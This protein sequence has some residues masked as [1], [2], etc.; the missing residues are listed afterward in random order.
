MTQKAFVWGDLTIAER[1]GAPSWGLHKDEQGRVRPGLKS[2]LSVPL[3]DVDDP[4]G[5]PMGTLQIDSDLP[6]EEFLRDPAAGGRI[7]ARFGD[8]VALL[9]KERG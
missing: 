3:V 9:L 6:I 2:I 8:V 7:A 5:E 4:Q 1:P